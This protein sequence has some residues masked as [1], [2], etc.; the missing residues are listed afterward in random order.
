MHSVALLS[1]TV[2]SFGKQFHVFWNS[3]PYLHLLQ[4]FWFITCEL[5]ELTYDERPPIVLSQ[6]DLEFFARLQ[7]R[8]VEL[9][10]QTVVECW[11]QMMNGVLTEA[12]QS[13]EVAR[14]YVFSIDN[15]T[16]L[17]YSKVA[18]VTAGTKNE[19]KNY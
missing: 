11:E 18:R 1:M 14:F 19:R 13:P 17:E 9:G 8:F 15:R 10:Q 6:L 5:A 3:Q 12:N 2:S 4:R 7:K 16:H